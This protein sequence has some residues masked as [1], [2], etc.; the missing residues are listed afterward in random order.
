MTAADDAA[1]LR[2]SRVRE[3]LSR[4]SR[5][6]PVQVRNQSGSKI[7][8]KASPKATGILSFG[9]IS[10]FSS[11]AQRCT[12]LM[13]FESGR[14]GLTTL[15]YYHGTSPGH[16]FTQYPWLADNLHCIFCLWPWTVQSLNQRDSPLSVSTA[17]VAAADLHT[18]C[19]IFSWWCSSELRKQAYVRLLL[20]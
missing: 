9:F 13:F 17:V 19:C 4:P 18:R 16:L 20:C 14:S 12:L 6:C 8:G 3:L 7:I 10:C 5:V 2:L 15:T 1:A 11:T